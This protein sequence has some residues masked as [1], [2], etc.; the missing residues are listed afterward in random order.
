MDINELTA[1][2]TEGLP[3]EQ[4]AIVKAQIE[5][6][7][8][9]TRIVGLKQQ[10]E[11]GDLETRA[12]TLQA[13]LDG[14]PDK[15]GTRAYQKWYTENYT[16][17]QKLQADR[18]AYEAKYGTL[19][20]PINPTPSPT[21]NPQPGLTAADIQRE[22]DKRIM[23]GYAPKWSELITQSGTV[24]ERHIRSGRKSPI[25]WKAVSE[26]AAAHGGD[27]NRAYDEWD[28]PEADKAAAAA[29]E[30][31]V[32]RR[33]NDELQK[34]GASSQFPAGADLTPGTL[35]SRTKAESDKF[36][37]TALQRDLASTWMSGGITQ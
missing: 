21:P 25:D 37:K 31:E 19:E 18:A 34:R 24:L 14:A 9:K 4:A 3:A 13:E 28:K 35:S 32:T 11:Y 12:A 30:A 7:A 15:P 29:T 16:A 33:V 23:E 20:N 6:D 10:K 17:I 36:D 27:L 5:K 2:L 26:K 22:V 8:N 1:W